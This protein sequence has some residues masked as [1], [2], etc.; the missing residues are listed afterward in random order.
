MLIFFHSEDSITASYHNDL[1]VQQT[2][3]PEAQLPAL[4]P[5]LVEHSSLKEKN[6]II[7]VFKLKE[8]FFNWLN[9]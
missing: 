8:D 2:P 9:F 5:P 1:H 6:E 7:Q 4:V 3:K